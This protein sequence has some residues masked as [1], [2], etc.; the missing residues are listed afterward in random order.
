MDGWM[1]IWRSSEDDPEDQFQDLRVIFRWSFFREKAIYFYFSIQF[2]YL[3]IYRHFHAISE[4]GFLG[5]YFRFDSSAGLGFSPRA[6]MTSHSPKTCTRGCEGHALGVCPGSA[7][8]AWP[9]SSDPDSDMMLTERMESMNGWI[10]NKTLKQLN[11][12]DCFLLMPCLAQSRETICSL[13]TSL[14]N[15]AVIFYGCFSSAASQTNSSIT[16]LQHFQRCIMAFKCADF[17]PLDHILL[18]KWFDPLCHIR[19]SGSLINASEWKAERPRSHW[20][21]TGGL[22]KRRPILLGC[23]DCIYCSHS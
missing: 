7:G 17:S 22:E 8:I 9:S 13:W 1:V 20:E 14:P 2:S 10:T 6:S 19:G 3:W 11:Q 5:C 16:V 4:Y 23:I 21:P 12:S 18:F 15:N